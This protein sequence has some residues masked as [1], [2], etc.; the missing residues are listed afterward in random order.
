MNLEG[1]CLFLNV[2]SSI[3]VVYS[4]TLKKKI[5]SQDHCIY[6]GDLSCGHLLTGS[7]FT[8][9][10]AGGCT[11]G[12][13]QCKSATYQSRVP[14]SQVE[15]VDIGV[16]SLEK[17]DEKPFVSINGNNN[18]VA[19]VCSSQQNQL[20]SCKDENKVHKKM[21]ND[22]NAEDKKATVFKGR[23][24]CFSETFPEDR[25]RYFAMTFL[26]F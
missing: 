10:G 3:S 26:L 24:F 16:A 23:K 20:S 4:V 8:N 13:N 2:V 5:L 11:I 12:M 15:N 1:C 14:S 6:I 25:V 19:T 17:N 22:C 7:L 9:K 21:Q 18:P